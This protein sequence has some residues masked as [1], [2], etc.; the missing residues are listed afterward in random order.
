MTR[1]EL[2]KSAATNLYRAADDDQGREICLD[3][4]A[5]YM[6]AAGLDTSMLDVTSA[7]G[8]PTDQELEALEDYLRGLIR[9][10]VMLE[11]AAA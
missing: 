4:A 9:A 7:C 1:A 2:I 6:R 5:R 8:G 11:R 3:R 10:P